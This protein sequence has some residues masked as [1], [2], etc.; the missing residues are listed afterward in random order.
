M[1]QLVNL[2]AGVV[3]RPTAGRGDRVDPALPPVYDLQGRPQE[4]AP[5]HPVQQ[6]VKCSRANAITVPIEFFH[7]GQAEDGFVLGVDENVNPY[8]AGEQIAL[9]GRLRQRRPPVQQLS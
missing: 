8:Q 5:L 3:E 2:D 6:G 1:V 4:A 7:H 9:T